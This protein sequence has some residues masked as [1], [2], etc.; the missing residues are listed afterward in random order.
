MARAKEGQTPADHR[1][2][3]RVSGIGKSIAATFPKLSSKLGSFAFQKQMLRAF[4]DIQP[5]WNLFPAPPLPNAAPVMNDF[6]I[7]RF[8]DGSIT[9][10]TGLKRFLASD[11][12]TTESSDI[13]LADGTILTS[14]DAVIFCTGYHADFSFCDPSADPTAFPTPEWDKFPHANGLEYPRLYQGLFSTLHPDSLAFIGP[15]RGHS[16]A[17]FSN[18]DLSSQAIAQI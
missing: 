1:M 6:I 9:P 10:V 13:E 17:A 4:P 16:F 18:S 11:D 7:S 2:T 14:I 15:Y 12:P 8:A 3:R 5:S